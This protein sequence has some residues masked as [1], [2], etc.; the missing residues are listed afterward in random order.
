[1]LPVEKCR[2]LLGEKGK[3]MSNQ[4]VIELRDFIYE[5]L[6]LADE[7]GVLQTN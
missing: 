3:G 7:G 4:D 5:V 1:M 6:R 2:D